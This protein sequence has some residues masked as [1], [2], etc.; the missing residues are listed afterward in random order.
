MQDLPTHSR[1]ITKNKYYLKRE[2]QHLTNI[3]LTPDSLISFNQPISVVHHQT[4]I[5]IIRA[6]TKYD[7]HMLLL[8]KINTKSIA[9]S[10]NVQNENNQKNKYTLNL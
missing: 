3:S 2:S 6:K 9:I 1:K 7:F 8:Q 5:V 10:Q 4:K